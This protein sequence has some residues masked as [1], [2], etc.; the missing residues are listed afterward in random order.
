M[1]TAVLALF[2]LLLL[3]GLA[4]AR[5]SPDTPG[6]VLIVGCVT[7]IGIHV[8]VNVAITLGLLPVTGLPLPLF[9]YGGS[10]YLTTMMC[11]GTIL[12]VHVR[13]RRIE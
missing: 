12:S 2:A 10:F 6:A 7:I 1:A 5:R 13:R 8:F 11:L 4:L 3:R 9:S